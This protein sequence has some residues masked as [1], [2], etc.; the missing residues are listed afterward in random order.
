MEGESVYVPSGLH[1]V[2]DIDTSP[3]LAAVLVEGSLIF[4]PNSDPNHVR[5]FDATYIMV[6]NGYMEVG[7][8]QF[9]YTSK[10]IITM[11]GEKYSPELPIYGNKVIA[12]RN[13][14]LDMHG[15]PRSP[16]WTE[17]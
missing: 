10:M 2:V 12:V 5:S 7:T 11:H 8:E 14:V 13:G 6:R 17:L 9:P 1:L 3:I 15:I 16:T 4:P